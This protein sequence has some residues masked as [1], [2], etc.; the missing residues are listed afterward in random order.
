MCHVTLLVT[1]HMCHVTT[2]FMGCGPTAGPH[3]SSSLP[4]LSPPPSRAQL[5]SPGKLFLIYF[6]FSSLFGQPHTFFSFG[7]HSFLQQLPPSPATIRYIYLPIFS[8]MLKILY[9]KCFLK[10]FFF[11]FLKCLFCMVCLVAEK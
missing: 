7:T 9:L 4:L 8:Y 2:G 11:F 6:L 10:C 3:P 5:S 1:W